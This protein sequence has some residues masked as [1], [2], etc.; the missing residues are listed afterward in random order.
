MDINKNYN[1]LTTLDDSSTILIKAFG[2][3][4]GSGE[5][6]LYI[7]HA[8][9]SRGV[10]YVSDSVN[11][12][13]TKYLGLFSYNTNNQINNMTF[14]DFDNN[15]ITDCIF[16]SVDVV[17]GEYRDTIQNFIFLFSKPNN[18]TISPF[19]IDDFDSD[20]KTEFIFSNTEGTIKAIESTG[21]NSYQT[22]LWQ[23]NLG[24]PNAHMSTVTNDIDGNGKKEFWIGGEDV[25]ADTP[26]I[27]IKCFEANVD[28]SYKG[29]AVIV[30]PFTYSLT[31]FRIL[32]NDLDNDGVEELIIQFASNIVIL[33]FAGSNNF[34][35]YKVAYLKIQESTQPGAEFNSLQ[36]ADLNLDGKKDILLPMFNYNSQSQYFSY[37]LS[38]NDPTNIKEVQK[39][40]EK[41]YFQ[42]YPNPF[43]L[44]TKIKYKISEGGAIK[45]KVYN[46]M[47]EE[48]A[49]LKD[50]YISPGEYEINWEAK[51]KYDISL[52]SGIYFISM[53]INNSI[54]VSKTILLK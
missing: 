31:V 7:R 25:G 4:N 16:S 24:L 53:Q 20:G 15:G 39:Q 8:S 12:L 45:I 17:I 5:K 38:Q 23:D 37:I 41:D 22:L 1:L 52:P 30:F 40:Q 32:A 3:I 14:G 29:K 28:N 2:N 47:G 6:D 21:I 10:I 35:Y 18:Y 46:L 48:I 50:E 49:V 51:N 44:S 43:N 13:P 34:H 42:S 27:A 33:K 26:M 9:S 11:M 19:A 36:I 54:K